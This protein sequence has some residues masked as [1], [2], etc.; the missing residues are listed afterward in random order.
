MAV[1]RRVCQSEGGGN[2]V[3]KSTLADAAAAAKVSGFDCRRLSA[4]LELQGPGGEAT[5]LLRAAR[6]VLPVCVWQCLLKRFHVLAATRVL[7]PTHSCQARHAIVNVLT[8]HTLNTH[9]QL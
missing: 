1:K 9:T 3:Q 4:L 2:K 6:C 7:Q 5:S 8:G